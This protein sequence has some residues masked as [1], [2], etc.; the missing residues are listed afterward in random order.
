MDKVHF[1]ALPLKRFEVQL[2]APS[3]LEFHQHEIETNTETF[4]C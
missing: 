2:A 1:L 4:N 3:A